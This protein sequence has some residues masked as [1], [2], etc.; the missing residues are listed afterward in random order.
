M[1]GRFKVLSS[2]YKKELDIRTLTSNNKTNSS[3]S[4]M[5]KRCEW[6]FLQS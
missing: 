2:T 1:L 5:D 3:V 4:K 6:A